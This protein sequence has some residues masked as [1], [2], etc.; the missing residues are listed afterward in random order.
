MVTG[1]EQLYRKQKRL[2]EQAIWKILVG[3]WCSQM[4]DSLFSESVGS[5]P[6]R[7]SPTWTLPV[8]AAFRSPLEG[9]LCMVAHAS[10]GLR[11]LVLGKKKCYGFSE[12]SRSALIFYALISRG[13]FFFFSKL[14]FGAQPLQAPENLPVGLEHSSGWFRGCRWPKSVCL[15]THRFQYQQGFWESNPY[16]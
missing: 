8:R 12:K 14:L 9:F 15:N 7:E 13:V 6:V 11:I 1:G 5:E 2:E 3:L 16:G 10:A 4:L